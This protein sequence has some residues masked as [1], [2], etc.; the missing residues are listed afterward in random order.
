MPQNACSRSS[1]LQPLKRSPAER[2]FLEYPPHPSGQS[3]VNTRENP[4]KFHNSDKT[5]QICMSGNIQILCPHVL[6]GSRL[7]P[8]PMNSQSLEFGKGLHS[9]EGTSDA[10]AGQTALHSSNI[11]GVFLPELGIH[12]LGSAMAMGFGDF[13]GASHGLLFRNLKG[14]TLA[15][16]PA[17][18][19]LFFAHSQW[20]SPLLGHERC[21][22]RDV[23][24]GH[25]AG[26]HLNSNRL[27]RK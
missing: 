7:W 13:S 22:Q 20:K 2:S 16:N 5:S 25:P 8:L 19:K 24:H 26:D 11:P 10:A 6:E 3:E 1:S 18:L 9:R 12:A 4:P 17:G 15:H 14:F 23:A 27:R 21:H